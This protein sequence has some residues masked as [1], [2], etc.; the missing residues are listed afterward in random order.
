MGT[1][2][3]ISHIL[4]VAAKLSSVDH[5]AKGPARTDDLAAMTNTHSSSLGRSSAPADKNGQYSNI[6]RFSTRPDSN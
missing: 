2:R 5:L 4:Y 6:A 1:A 3:W